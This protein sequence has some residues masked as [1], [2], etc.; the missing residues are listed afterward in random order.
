VSVRIL[1]R[2]LKYATYPFLGLSV[3]LFMGTAFGAAFVSDFTIENRTS[4]AIV[5][6]PVGTFGAG[7]RAPLPVKML[8][9]LPIPAF[10]GGDYPLAPGESVTVRYDTD[11]INLSEIVV[12]AE[13]DRMLQLVADPIPTAN[14][15]HGPRQRHYIIDDLARLGPAPPPVQEAVRVADRQWVVA[16]VVNSLLFGPWLLCVLFS[17]LAR[18]CAGVSPTG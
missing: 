11:D 5:V 17:W 7:S 18:R 6:T 8:V 13:P 15:Y 9:I 16:C 10:R 12:V 4:S 14:Q 1:F 3:M 2:V